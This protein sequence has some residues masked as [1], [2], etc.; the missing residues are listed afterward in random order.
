MTAFLDGTEK[1]LVGCKKREKIEKVTGS[2]DD[3]GEGDASIRT[4]WL[5]ERT[6]GPSTSLR[7]GRDDNFSWGLASLT[8]YELLSSQTLQETRATRAKAGSV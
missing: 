8:K 2:Q 3:E 5:V 7:F 1:Y 4:R 6:A